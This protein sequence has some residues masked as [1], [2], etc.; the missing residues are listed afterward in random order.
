MRILL[1]MDPGLPVPPPLYGGHE[2]LVSLFA[3]AYVRM[4]H[5][6]SVL[7]GPGSATA[8]KNYHFGSNKLNR[9]R[10]QRMKELVS[11][12]RFLRRTRGQFDLVHNFGRLLYLLPLLNH[13]VKKI[14]SYGRRVSPAGIRQ[15][16]QLPN[17]NLVFTACSDYCVSTGNVA[18]RWQTVYNAVDFAAYDLKGQVSEDAPLMFL[19]RLDQTKGPH[20]AIEVALASG[21]RLWIGGNIPTTPDNLEY[22]KAMVEPRIDGRRIIYLGELDDARK[23]EY[24]GRS[25][26]L[27]FPIEGSEAFGLVMAEAMACGTPVIGFGISSVPEVIDEGVTG[28][29]VSSK[30]EMTTAVSR[31]PF[32]DR[33]GCRE[34]AMSRFDV[35]VIAAHYLTLFKQ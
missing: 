35:R 29:V 22:F 27:L 19:G 23:N 32:I 8:G 9:S 28:F 16:N 33:S 20:T 4:G 14:M 18:G 26:A 13:P 21:R 24:L 5:E 34:R 10:F 1:I 3:E 17:R 7:S 11:A 30:E 2:R 25:A 15:I 31:I 12:W 6:V